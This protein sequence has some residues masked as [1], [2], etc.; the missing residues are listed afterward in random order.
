[1]TPFRAT[2][3]TFRKHSQSIHYG[4]GATQNFFG[5]EK[6]RCSFFS[7][8]ICRKNNEDRY[9][10]CLIQFTECPQLSKHCNIVKIIQDEERRPEFQQRLWCW[11]AEWP[12]ASHLS[13]P[14]L[15]FLGLEMKVIEHVSFPI[16]NRSQLY[17]SMTHCSLRSLETFARGQV[18]HT[19]YPRFTH[20]CNLYSREGTFNISYL[21][22]APECK[23]SL[24]SN[25]L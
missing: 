7:H 21:L 9:S 4:Y 3:S 17:D 5:G 1:M 13:P 18:N 23:F 24:H 11:P 2:Q 15:N 20:A 6:G 10:I 16:L 14:G 22:E 8:P 25:A 19:H 12:W